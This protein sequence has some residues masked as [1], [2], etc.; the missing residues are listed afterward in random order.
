MPNLDEIDPERPETWPVS[1]W[2]YLTRR[3]PAA[4]D[5]RLRDA[6]REEIRASGTISFAR[7]MQRALYDPEHGYYATAAGQVGAA[8]DFVTAPTLHPAFGALLSRPIGRLG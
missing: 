3:Q 4:E 1:A 2:E 6:L 5:A 7:F 8:G